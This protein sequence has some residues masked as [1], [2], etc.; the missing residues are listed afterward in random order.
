MEAKETQWG[1][2]KCVVVLQCG[3]ISAN[4]LR[5]VGGKKKGGESQFLDLSLGKEE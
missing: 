4:E 2:P 1:A 5:D 3:A